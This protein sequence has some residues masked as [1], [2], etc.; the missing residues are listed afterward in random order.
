MG[1]GNTFVLKMK[2]ERYN[3]SLDFNSFVITRSLTH[4][5]PI[6]NKYKLLL[7]T[8]SQIA[9]LPDFNPTT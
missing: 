9:S 3:Q 1:K 6:I 5:T 8:L 2:R 4:S 7:T